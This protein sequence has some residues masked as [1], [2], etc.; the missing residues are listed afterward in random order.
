[1]LSSN[2]LNV[3]EGALVYNGEDELC[4]NLKYNVK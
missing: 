1:M 2:H 4:L 3:P